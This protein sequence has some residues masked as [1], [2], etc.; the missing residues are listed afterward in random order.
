M[1]VCYRRQTSSLFP[2]KQ[3]SRSNDNF[4]TDTPSRKCG[5]VSG[6]SYF[7]NQ[8]SRSS[9]ACILNVD[10]CICCLSP[11]FLW[12]IIWCNTECLK[13][14]VQE[15]VFARSF[16]ILSLNSAFLGLFYY[17]CT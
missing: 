14:I 16:L 8:V 2:P 11:G 3:C 9:L 15:S 1:Q 17:D 6:L 13:R 4:C 10:S 5:D 12:Q 7:R